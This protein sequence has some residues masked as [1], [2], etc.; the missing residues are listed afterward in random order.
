MTL[1]NPICTTLFICILFLL[2]VFAVKSIFNFEGFNTK[3]NERIRIYQSD[4]IMDP[5]ESPEMED[6]DPDDNPLMFDPDQ[7][8]LLN[9]YFTTPN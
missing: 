6:L 2:L 1:K 9:A 3:R 8:P 7:Q 4:E 5:D